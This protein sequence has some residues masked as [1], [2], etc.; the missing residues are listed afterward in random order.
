MAIDLDHLHPVFRARV[1]NACQARSTSVFSG[2]RSTERQRQLYE[3]FLAGRGNPANPPGSSWHEYDPTTIDDAASS[4]VGGAHALAVD[5]AEPYPHGE[6]GI[7]FRLAGE[8]WHGQP[9]EIPE[10]SRV[11]G[12]WRRLPALTP[13][14]PPAPPVELWVNLFVP[15]LAS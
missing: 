15:I 11:I 3:D 9:S 7:I 13:P 1:E 2:A 14:A 6:P 12:A 5:F 10:T 8:P 4:L